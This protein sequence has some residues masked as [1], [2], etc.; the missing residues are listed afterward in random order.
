MPA[1]ALPDRPDLDQYR[2]QAKDLLRAWRGGDP[3]AIARITTH[4]PRLRSRG[5]S[6]EAAFQLADA[7]LVIAREHGDDSWTAFAAG[8][9][10]RRHRRRAAGAAVETGRGRRRPRRRRNARRAAARARRRASPGARVDMVRRARAELRRRRGAGDHRARALLRQLGRLRVVRRRAARS[11]LADRPVRSRGRGHR[12][13]RSRDA[14]PPAARGSGPG[15]GAV[16]AP[17]SRH[18]VP[19][20]RLERRRGL[21]PARAEEPRR[22]RRGT[23]GR[24]RR[25]ER[26]RA[27]VRRARHHAALSR[28]PA[29]IPC[30]RAS[31]SRCS[32]SSSTAA[33]RVDET[34]ARPGRR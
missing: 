7:Q 28:P 16:G 6:P 27:D 17:A 1:R 3:Q 18:A 34:A 13:W 32:P 9:R 22:H 23:A 20:R 11:A 12:R 26:H 29:S 24:R 8:S 2:K 15:A 10:H 33:P 30:S 5:A 21:P 19:L 14:G 4:H 25:R 31:S